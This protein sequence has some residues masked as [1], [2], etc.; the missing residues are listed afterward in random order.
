[1]DKTEKICVGIILI[2]L[3][4]TGGLCLFQI[5]KNKQLTEGFGNFMGYMINITSYCVE[6]NNMTYDQLL[7]GYLRYETDKILEEFGNE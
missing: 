5:E 7:Q 4:I 6:I 2:F 1:M 3:V